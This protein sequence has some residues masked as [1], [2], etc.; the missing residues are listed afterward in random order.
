MNKTQRKEESQMVKCFL[1]LSPK[2][3]PLAKVPFMTL[4]EKKRY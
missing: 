1:V 2:G 4:S 3:L